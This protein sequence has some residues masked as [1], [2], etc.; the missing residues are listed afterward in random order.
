[1]AFRGIDIGQESLFD[2]SLPP[3]CINWP[4]EQYGPQSPHLD[5]V[6]GHSHK[7]PHIKRR[8]LPV[9]PSRPIKARRPKPS[10]VAKRKPEPT[11][12][13]GPLPERDQPLHLL[14]LPGELRDMIYDILALRDEPQYAQL[15]PVLERNGRR[16]VHLV[17]RHPQEPVLALVNKQLRH[18]V[19]SVF[20][21]TNRFIFRSSH[22]PLLEAHS[23]AKHTAIGRWKTTQ[24]GYLRHIELKLDARKSLGLPFT[25]TYVLK[26]GQDG[27]IKIT[28]SL[29]GTDYCRC[30][31]DDAVASTLSKRPQGDNDLVAVTVFLS[32]VRELKLRAVA[33]QDDDE[34][35]MYKMPTTKCVICHKTNLMHVSGG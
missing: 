2:F 7:S 21:G 29:G 6:K 30:I 12:E 35:G 23:M 11:K 18:E 25:V 8:P 13:H 9:S 22:E 3:G 33:K 16:L 10:T 4:L 26:K 19:L 34:M 14:D 24:T 32:C 28:H 20:Y 31:E 5:F 1:M 17:R 15:R 27:Q